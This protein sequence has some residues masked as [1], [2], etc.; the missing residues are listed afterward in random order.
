VRIY[1]DLIVALSGKFFG[2][3]RAICWGLGPASGVVD[4]SPCRGWRHTISASIYDGKRALSPD[5]L[6]GNA[7]HELAPAQ[8]G[9]PS[10]AFP[11]S[12]ERRIELDFAG[13]INTFV[14]L[15]AEH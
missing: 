15:N 14:G 9:R 12:G 13:S 10:I 8:D 6:R 7:L 3:T 5:S 11:R 2:R 4:A 1:P